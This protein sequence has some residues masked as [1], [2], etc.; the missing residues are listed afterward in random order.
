MNEKEDIV[1]QESRFYQAY[2]AGR[3]WIIASLGVIITIVAIILIFFISSLE[4]TSEIKA[5]NYKSGKILNVWRES[6][7]ITDENVFPAV[8]ST[9]VKYDGREYYYIE[10]YDHTG[11]VTDWYFAF[12]GG[13][14]YV[15]NDYKY[16]VLTAI[17]AVIAVFV[18]YI[19][20]SSAVN[21]GKNTDKFTKSLIYYKDAKANVRGFFHL[22]P[23]FCID[24]NKERTNIAV[25]DIV[26]EAGLLYEDYVAGKVEKD[27][28][29][30][31]Q[32]KILKKIKKI[33]IK[34]LHSTDLL[35]EKTKSGKTIRMLP[36]GESENQRNFLIKSALQ[37]VIT[38]ALSGIVV[39][40]GVVLGNWT[41]G[42]TYGF[43]VAMGAVTA[44]IAGSDYVYNVLRNR[45]ITKADY[46]IEFNDVKEKYIEEVITP[47]PLEEDKP[48]LLKEGEPNEIKEIILG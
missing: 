40:F 41:L 39:A 17:V 13:L 48:K 3:S 21:S 31:W 30:K 33:K 38:I 44:T 7:G 11:E 22:I 10:E 23:M 4:G 42:A 14:Q 15:F 2:Q 43:T 34:R 32:N 8:K 20:Y 47:T 12:E 35:Q 25:R 18:S 46:L 9:I 29:E 28:L 6:E 27:K 16:Y 45:F 1:R 19:N 36:L 24:K 5:G 37:K 26:E